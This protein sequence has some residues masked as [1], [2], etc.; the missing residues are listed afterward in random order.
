[1]KRLLKVI[2]IW[3]GILLAAC[4]GVGDNAAA[5]DSSVVE[6]ARAWVVATTNAQG[7][8]ALGLTCVDL[9]QAVQTENLIG[10]G[11]SD[12]LRL[13][14][15]SSFKADFSGL[16]YQLVDRE[17]ETAVVQVN[18]S[19]RLV[20]F[21]SEVAV[22]LNERWIMRKEDGRWRWCGSTP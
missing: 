11:L 6:A 13:R 19:A 5:T 16:T 12:L 8:Q 14:L 9:R 3:L 7:I 17:R 18:G 21:G 20:A 15:D 1:M 2:P 10:T 22:E 4:A